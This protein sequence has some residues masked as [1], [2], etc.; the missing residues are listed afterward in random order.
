M[1]RRADGWADEVRT[2]PDQ[3]PQTVV[4][5]GRPADRQTGRCGISSWERNPTT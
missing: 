2:P 4:F 5:V 3:A 1:D